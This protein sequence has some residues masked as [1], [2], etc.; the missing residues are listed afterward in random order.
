MET[1]QS[2]AKTRFTWPDVAKGICIISV[3]LGHLGIS[4]INRIVFIYHLPVFYIL[5]GYFLTKKA[6]KEFVISKA[7]RLLVPYYVTCAA[8]SLI[9][10][11]NSDN[12]KEALLSWGIASL[13]GAGDS[14]HKPFEVNAIGAIWFL[15][16]IFWALLILNHFI[17][18]K[19]YKIIIIGIA[20]FGWASFEI[21]KIWFPLSIQAGMLASLYLLIGYEIKKA[22]LLEKLNCKILFIFFIVFIWGI[23]NFKGFWLVHNYMGN[24]LFDFIA[25][26]CSAILIIVFSRFVSTHFPLSTKML[27]WFGE[28]S[29]T[30]L[31]FHI[32]EL[33]VLPI[34]YFIGNRISEMITINH[35]LIFLITVT[36]KFIFVIISTVIFNIII[37]KFHAISHM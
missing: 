20:F 30:I 13:Y 31:C 36:F 27:K 11:L 8:M 22:D 4:Y 34:G 23:I 5:A 28:N 25:S 17:E 12:K 37:R 18:S 15:W 21:S 14:W 2:K 32:I 35:Y 1:N 24:G 26:L 10:I 19:Y 6:D 7:K 33:N 16:A 29:L 9:G 3:I